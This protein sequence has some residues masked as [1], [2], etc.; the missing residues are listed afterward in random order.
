[1]NLLEHILLTF[2]SAL[3]FHLNTLPEDFSAMFVMSQWIYDYLLVMSQLKT[4]VQ[5][6][7]VVVI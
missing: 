4:L 5:C 2:H 3:S 6:L 7:V 1:M